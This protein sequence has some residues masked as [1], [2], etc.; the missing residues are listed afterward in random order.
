MT[1]W[2]D[3]PHTDMQAR[4][5]L[6]VLS[7]PWSWSS[8]LTR[9][10]TSRLTRDGRSSPMRTRRSCGDSHRLPKKTNKFLHRKDK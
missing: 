8:A 10:R 1:K 3:L 5:A 4:K 7:P 9:M 2:S 6:N